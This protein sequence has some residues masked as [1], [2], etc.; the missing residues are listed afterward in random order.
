MKMI[1][2]S[3]LPGTGKSMLAESL[4][5]Q[6]VIPVFARDWLEASLLR[7]RLT[8]AMTEESLG[9]AGYHLLTTLAE[10]QLMLSQSVILDSVA[11]TETIRNTWR[12]L[13]KQFNADWRVIECFCSDETLHRSRLEIRQRNIPGWHELTWSD[14]EKVKQYYAPWKEERLTL[15]MIYPFEENYAKARAYCE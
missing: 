7:S 9:F 2:F 1:V 15:D 10:R 14:I 13:A 6:L 5:K 12:E 4:G 3:G 8:P 11:S